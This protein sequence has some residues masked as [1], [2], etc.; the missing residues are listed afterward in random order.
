[1][2][3]LLHWLQAGLQ[4]PEEAAL[5][6][7]AFPGPRLGRAESREVEKRPLGS[8]CAKRLEWALRGGMGPELPPTETAAPQP[9]FLPW[10][11]TCFGFPI[12]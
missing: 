2:Y 5:V 6:L 8:V 4:D 11:F 9:A 7:S 3:R 10:G 1:M 12:A